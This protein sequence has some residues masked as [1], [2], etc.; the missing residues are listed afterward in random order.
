LDAREASQHSQGTASTTGKEAVGTGRNLDLP[1]QYRG[2]FH[3]P[4]SVSHGKT[5]PTL[6]HQSTLDRAASSQ[7]PRRAEQR[8][9]DAHV[10]ECRWAARVGVA[11]HRDRLPSLADR[12]RH[13]VAIASMPFKRPSDAGDAPAEDSPGHKVKLPR[14]ERNAEDFSSVVKSKLQSYTRTGQA[15]DRCKVRACVLLLATGA[16]QVAERRHPRRGYL[17][18]CQQH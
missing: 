14:L 6:I 9:I 7:D 1:E 15:C 12:H 3:L 17:I 13:P 16:L 11:P 5:R 8:P 18:A 10:I 4:P 2:I